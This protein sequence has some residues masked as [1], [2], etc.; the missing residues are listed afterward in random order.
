MDNSRSVINDLMVKTFYDILFIEQS[1][2]KHGVFSDLTMTEMH[3][4]TAIGLKG[5]KTMGQVARELSVTVGTLTVAVKSLVNKSYASRFHVEE[6]RRLVKV[7]LTKKGR[8]AYRAH[9]R[10]HSD[11][12]RYMVSDLSEEEERVLAVSIS[13]LNEY[14]QKYLKVII[15]KAGGGA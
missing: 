2:L 13:R 15:T 11:M 3:T 7:I 9:E 6:D 1:A 8:L 12:V 10:F 14:L 4:I 5:Q